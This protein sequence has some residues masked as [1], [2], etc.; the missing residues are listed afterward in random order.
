MK[1][2]KYL[3]I[4]LAASLLGLGSCHDELVNMTPPSDLTTA[5][6]FKTSTDLDLAMVAVYNSLQ[7]RKPNDYMLLELPADNLYR[8]SYTSDAGANE[9]DNLGIT[10]ENPLLAIFWERSYAG[11]VRANT[12]LANIEVP[13]DYKPGQKDQLIGEARF[14]RALLYFDLVRLFGGVPLVLDLVTVDEARQ[15]PKATEEQVYNVIIDDLKDALAKLPPQSG[16]AKGRA[17]KGAA[18]ALLGKVYVYRKDWNNAKTQLESVAGFG[19]ELVPAFAS[20]WGLEDEDNKEFIFAM[21][22]TDGTNGHRMTSDFLPFIG[23]TGISS[24]GLEGVF[25]SWD[26]HK[27]YVTG[28]SRKASTIN[29]YYKPPTPA[30]APT[31][32]F[33]HVAKFEVKQT[34]QASG[35][36]IP[37]LRYADV[38]LLLAETYYNLNRPDLALI[39]LNRIRARAFGNVLH[40]YTVLDIATPEAFMDKLLLERR[41][42]LAFEN[43][44]WF[45]LVRSGR[46]VSE[47]SKEE[48]GYNFDAQTVLTVTLQPQAHYRLYPIP[49]RQIQRAKPDVLVQNTGYN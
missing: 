47:L 12:L 3:R 27:L 36:D 15:M 30:N 34:N 19:Y 13:T 14:M 44:R 25:P 33:P 38:V 43:E 23:K 21:K 1:H 46:L 8:S 48:R 9:M 16:I 41:L 40:N 17:S 18:A 5:D 26:L 42:E 29:E 24:A 35:I 7:V 10:P 22:Y 37:V 31:I 6:F 2:I 4:C 28:D 20:L 32:W 45:D 11:I 49:L 39:E